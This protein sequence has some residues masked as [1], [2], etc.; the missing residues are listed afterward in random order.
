MNNLIEDFLNYL[1]VERGLS[2]NTIYNYRFDL[3]KF[4]DYLN[5]IKKTDINGV[6]KEIIS[7]LPMYLKGRKLSVPSI[8]RNLIAVKTFFK[9]LINEKI[10]QNDIT[11]FF[12]S[13]KLW[14]KLPDTL[15][16]EEIEKIISK[17]HLKTSHSIR[18][19]AIL[20]ILYGTG[21]RVSEVSGLK[22]ENVNFDVGFLKCKGKGE[23]E[24]IVPFGGKAKIAMERYLKRARPEF[25][26]KKKNVP[27]MFLS[28]LGRPLSRVS[29]WKMVKFYAKEARIRKKITPHTFRHSF[30]SH[31][32]ERG[33]DLRIVQE[34]L[35]HVDIST[36]QI[37]THINKDRLRSIHQKFHPRP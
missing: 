4:F 15:N 18:D 19:K 35:G 34:L 2:G 36:T 14:K 21:M 29:I 7:A 16:V 28:R 20:E 5:K 24:R 22:T 3:D 27:E 12:E 17:P 11:A 9:Y 37:Y 6:N 31:M 10:I 8:A 32:L 26:S 33:A 1:S 25:I 30:A 23:K 13:P